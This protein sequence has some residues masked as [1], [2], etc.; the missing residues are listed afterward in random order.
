MKNLFTI[1][2]SSLLLL[3]SVLTSCETIE[4]TRVGS[5]YGIV[6]KEGSTEPLS[7]VPVGLYKYNSLMLQTVT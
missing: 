2:I 4:Q 5:I 6:T 3:S 7:A 1:I